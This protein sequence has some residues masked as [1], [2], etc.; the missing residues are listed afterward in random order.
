MREARGQGAGDSGVGGQRKRTAVQDPSAEGDPR[1][2]AGLEAGGGRPGPQHAAARLPRP[3]PLHPPG[4]VPR[5]RTPPGS[6]GASPTGLQRP[7]QRPLYPRPPPAAPASDRRALCSLPFQKTDLTWPNLQLTVRQAQGRDW[8]GAGRGA[9]RR[10]ELFRELE[11]EAAQAET[12]LA[13]TSGSAPAELSPRG[14]GA[15][16]ACRGCAAQVTAAGAH[17]PACP[18]SVM[19][20]EGTEGLGDA[21][22]SP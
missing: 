7:G 21:V 8:R 9:Q 17:P 19:S 5:L 12:R 22:P 15:P 16:T 20:A 18:V 6:R 14:G 10:P 3:R 1:K 4:A 11:P 13:G 2:G